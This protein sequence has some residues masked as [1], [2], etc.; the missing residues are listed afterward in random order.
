LAVLAVVVSLACRPPEFR[1]ILQSPQVVEVVVT[2]AAKTNDA[3][4]LE[5][6]FA[7]ALRARLASYAT[8]VPE[9]VTPPKGALRLTVEID[10]MSWK[11]VNAAA[12]GAG[13]AIAMGATRAASRGYRYWGGGGNDF[14][15]AMDMIL[16][17]L[18]VAFNIEGN[19]QYRAAYLGFFPPRISG[20][21]TLSHI[22]GDYKKPL[23]IEGLKSARIIDAL[24]PISDIRD[25][26]AVD[27]E[28][29]RA[30]AKV[31][32]GKLIAALD[33]RASEIPT[34]YEPTDAAR[35]D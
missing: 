7:S 29:A 34:W 27:A 32:V 28:V 2:V 8:V 12:V 18:D 5:R 22:D 13:A 10:K 33:W 35:P 4:D 9:G 6:E 20:L 3:L 1:A 16:F 24:S 30:I 15:A 19:Q 11:R 31:V 26:G 25:Q 23:L 14:L 17:G 21:I